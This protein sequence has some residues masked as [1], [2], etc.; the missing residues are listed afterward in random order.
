MALKKGEKTVTILVSLVLVLVLVNLVATFGLYGK[1]SGLT[2]GKAVA[3]LPTAV[4]PSAPSAP[5]PTPTRVGGDLTGGDPAKGDADAKVT[6]VEFS[7]FE[8]PFCERFYTQ[9]LPQIKQRYIDTGKV[10]FVYRHY[11]LPFHPS[12]Q[13]AAEA[14]ECAKDQ[15]KFWEMHDLLFSRGVQGGV[16]SFKQYAQQLGLDQSKFDSCLDSDEKADE[17]QQDLA[18]GTNYGVRGTPGFFVNGVPISG[19]QPFQNFAS[20]IE[21]ELNK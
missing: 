16:A 1:F 15:G 8:C 19:A 12:A 2:T 10:K 5:E 4:A 6:I 14:T 18:D 20:I 21:Q 13:K 3:A 7:D 11:P 9:T 17:V